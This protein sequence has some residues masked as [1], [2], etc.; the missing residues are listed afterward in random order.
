MSRRDPWAFQRWAFEVRT[1][2]P[3]RKAVL[4]SLA[5][6][7]DTNTGRCEAEQ[8][9]IAQQIENGERTVRRALAD[10]EAA[11]LIARR[12]QYRRDGARR[13]DEFLLLAPW[14]SEWPDGEALPA[15]AAGG[16][17]STTGQ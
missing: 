9:T 12:H 3:T 16:R 7:A 5:V 2:N 17:R 8:A 14:V 11:I 15:R 13:C 4:V 1:G 10:L 6:M